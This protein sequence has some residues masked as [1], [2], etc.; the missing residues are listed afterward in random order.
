MDLHYKGKVV[1]ITGALGGIGR[2]LVRRFQDEGA[3]VVAAGSRAPDEATAALAKAF[4]HPPRYVMCDYTKPETISAAISSAAPEIVIANAG[5]TQSQLVTEASLEDWN[6][7]V[8]V[9]F[10]GNFLLG[11]SAARH[12]TAKRSGAILFIGS[13]AQLVP[14]P[15]IGAYGPT[16]AGMRMLALC[17][18]KELAPLGVRVNIL[19]LGVIDTGMAASNMALQPE[20]RVWANQVTLCGRLG[21]AEE[22]ADAAVFLCSSRASFIYGAE[23]LVDGGAI[24][25]S[26]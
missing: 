9:N 7:L 1:L 22:V 4:P 17:L 19:T 12:L 13:S 20:R 26:H 10:T 14:K 23:L 18:A 2:G 24:L 6:R 11:Q 25:G 16:K 8:A 21:T 5:I 3:D 15:N